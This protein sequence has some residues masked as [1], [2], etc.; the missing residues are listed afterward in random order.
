MIRKSNI[1]LLRIISMMMVLLLHANYDSLGWV[2]YD[3]ISDNPSQAC[4]RIAFEQLCII[5]VNVFVF[6]SGWFGIKANMKGAL[7]LFFQVIFYHVL[8]LFLLFFFGIDFSIN[9]FVIGFYFGASY[10]FVVS[11]FILYIFTPVLN[12]FIKYSSL[13]TFFVVVVLFY[14]SQFIFDWIYSIP[15]AEFHSGYSALSFIG[16]YLLAQLLRRFEEH[17]LKLGAKIYILFYFLFSL[18]PV[19]LFL[20]TGSNLNTLDYTSIFVLLSSVSFFLLFNSFKF[21]SSLVNFLACSS[22]SIYLIHQ[23]PLVIPFY[24]LSVQYIFNTFSGIL[25]LALIFLF[26]I[27]FSLACIFIDK[28]RIAVW[29][30]ICLKYIDKVL[31]KIS[32]VTTK[33]F[34]LLGI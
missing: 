14:L 21:S 19:V 34:E 26:V 13:R 6:I 28:I 10:W 29:N 27:F 32:I 23:H 31:A 7:S 15:G 8:I 25:F 20:L 9:D 12:V 16:I 11:Y 1:E 30:Y 2:E 4:F 22:F 17:L 18:I 5:S 33:S 3:D 24:R